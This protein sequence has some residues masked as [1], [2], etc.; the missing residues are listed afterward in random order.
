[1]KYLL[2]LVIFL[3]VSLRAESQII[4][5][6]LLFAGDS[7]NVDLKTQ[8]QMLLADSAGIIARDIWVAVF[9][10]PKKM[11]RMYEHYQVEHG[12]FT[13]LLVGRGGV[14][15]FRS[16]TPVPAERLFDIIDHLPPPEEGYQTQR[17]GGGR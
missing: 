9:T 8:R 1:M 14:E 5:R 13:L 4:R 11:R 12:S 2:F 6:V 10:A 16:E 17:R 7:T 3:A 15:E